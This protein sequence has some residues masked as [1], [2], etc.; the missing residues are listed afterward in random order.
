MAW[1]PQAGNQTSAFLADWCDILFYG[2]ERGGG[3][4]DF[5]LGYQEDAALRYEGKSRGIMIRKTNPELEELQLR[6][7][8]I[9]PATGAVFKKQPSE[10]YPFS[11]CWYWPNGASVKMR[12]LEHERDYGRYHGHQYSHIS[13]DEAPEYYSPGGMDK[14]I[15]TMRSAHGVPCTMR[16]TGNPGGVGTSW[17]KHR[18]IDKAPPCSPWVDPENGLTYMWVRSKLADNMILSESDPGY[19]SRLI[20]ATTGNTEL[21]K[22]WLSGDWDVVAGAFFSQFTRDRHVVKPFHIP[23]HWTRIRGF[24]WGRASPFA[25]LWAAVSDGTK[26]IE[27]GSDELTIPRGA[28]VFYREWYGMDKDEIGKGLY[29]DDDV[30]AKGIAKRSA[31][32]KFEMSNSVADPSIFNVVTGKSIAETYRDNGVTFIKAD[33][34]RVAGWGQVH[35]RLN[36]TE[37][38]E[39]VPMIYFFDT[40]T[41]TIR[42]LPL[43]QHDSSN[44]ED[45]DTNMEDHA[46][47]ALRYICMT[48]PVVRTKPKK[49]KARFIDPYR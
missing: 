25:A 30:V 18:F 38:S 35:T 24:D 14:M 16:L 6:A 40:M 26:V 17:I 20:A 9:F 43:L 10:F 37:E 1:N 44:I 2:G 11:N 12:Y 42:T 21:R 19:R 4:S 23:E 28:L 8:E 49:A 45:L 46:A 15:S 34:S 27:W 7:M 32:E 5:H 48:R 41:H 22:A 31:G 36:G 47:D 33:N 3:K 39:G 13:L 29:F